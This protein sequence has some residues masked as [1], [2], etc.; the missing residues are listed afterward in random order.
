MS[1]AS[2]IAVSGLNVASLRLRVSASNIANA[3]SSGPLPGAP[4]PENFPP[5]YSHLR[6]NQ[7]DVVGGGTS[8][9]M[10]AVSP[11]TVA[12]FDPTAPFADSRGIV[13]SPNIDLANELVQTLIARYSFAANAKVIHVDAQMSADLFDITA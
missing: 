7:V 1:I 13:A 3:L 5:A 10:T 2:T 12:T 8:A 9:S 11:S 6:V 4:N